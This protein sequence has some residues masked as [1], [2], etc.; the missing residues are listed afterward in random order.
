MLARSALI[1]LPTI[2]GTAWCHGPQGIAAAKRLGVDR[3]AYVRILQS[4]NGREVL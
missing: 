1:D 3:F 2:E 4:I